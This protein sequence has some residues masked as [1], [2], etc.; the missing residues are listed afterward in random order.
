MDVPAAKIKGPVL[1]AGSGRDEVWDS[2]PAVKRIAAELRDSHFPYRHR[3]LY[4]AKAGHG[5]GKAIALAP[6]GPDALAKASAQA[7]ARLW[8]AILSF[9]RDLRRR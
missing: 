1:V 9:M 6:S 7:R 8:P 4:F 3:A 5:V 2:G